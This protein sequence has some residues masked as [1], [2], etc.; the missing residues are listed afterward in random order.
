MSALA[1]GRVRF[2]PTHPAGIQSRIGVLACAPCRYLNEHMWDTKSG[3]Y[4][5]RH[6][7]PTKLADAM[8]A[9]ATS[10][11]GAAATG[12]DLST[13]HSIASFW[14]LLAGI[15]APKRVAQLVEH[16][17]DPASFNRPVRVPSLSAAHPDYKADGGYWEGGVW[18]PTTYMVLRGLTL[19]EADDVAADIGCN[20]HAA[21]VKVFESTGTVWEN[22]APV[23]RRR[24]L[25]LR[26]AAL[27]PAVN[28]NRA[29]VRCR[30]Q[31]HATSTAA[32]TS[33]SAAASVVPVASAADGTGGACATGVA[34]PVP[35]SPAKPDFVGWSGLGPIAVLYE[36]VFGIR[37]DVP[38]GEL[39]LDVRLLDA[40]GVTNFPFG[41][42]G[43]VCIDV[44]ARASAVNEPVVT[45]TSTVAVTVVVTWGGTMTDV[46]GAPADRTAVRAPHKRQFDVAPGLSVTAADATPT[47]ATA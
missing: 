44:G 13:V 22:L 2:A 32:S 5:D 40:Y 8:T 9:G 7:R 4:V 17:D 30:L 45:V 6:L 27:N 34:G 39:R 33:I 12:A 15:V 35:G 25:S 21:V 3:I 38:R 42:E 37:A 29:A 46:G 31:E 11:A 20:Y 36:Y 28:M 47:A 10:A 19:A 23:R 43:L 18:A 14:P 1:R 26:A 41:A 24:R 16:L